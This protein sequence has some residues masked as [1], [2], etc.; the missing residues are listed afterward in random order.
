MSTDAGA[1]LEQYIIP[2]IGGRHPRAEAEM[3]VV[4]EGSHALGLA[5]ELADLD[6]IIY[7][8]D[9]L[10]HREGGQVQL[11]LWREA[12]PFRAESQR[13]C[14]FPGRPENWVVYGHP[15]VSV[16][17]AS[18]LLE[19]QAAQ[20][21]EGGEVPWE[22]IS[23]EALF[24]LH[25]ETLVLRD[26]HQM[27]ATLRQATRPE[28]LPEWLWR[29]RLLMK[30]AEIKGLPAELEL[31]VKRGETVEASILLGSLLADLLRAGFLMAK[32]YHPY[33]KRLRWAFAKLFLAET[34]LP[35]IDTISA[36][37]EWQERLQAVQAL[38]ARYA[39]II[40]DTGAL[41]SEVLEYLYPARDRQAWSNPDWLRQVRAEERKARDAGCEAG[42]RWL[43]SLWDWE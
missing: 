36:S 19:G 18:W 41:A 12:E 7:L 14:D 21:L 25:C 16:H 4:I 37:P 15:E 13:Y 6:A 35:L 8:E 40:L 2:L 17:P 5:D 26:P 20:V 39:E 11:L 31:A 30:L 3:C 10:W 42:D 27:I 43:W 24:K 22:K 34:T 33:P 38:V 28:Y 9:D 32:V 1:Y 23:P 29:K